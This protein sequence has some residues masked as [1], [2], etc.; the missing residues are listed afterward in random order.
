MNIRKANRPGCRC[1]VPCG[2]AAPLAQD[3]HPRWRH[4]RV[5]LGAVAAQHR[6]RHQQIGLSSNLTVA[7]NI[8]LGPSALGWD[9]NKMHERAL[10]AEH[11]GHRPRRLPEPTTGARPWPR[12]S[13][14]T[15]PRAPCSGPCAARRRPDG[16]GR[17][18]RRGSDRSGLSATAVSP[19]GPVPGRYRSWLSLPPR[20][21]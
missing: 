2:A 5:R 1:N 16:Q 13:P 18:G 3:R 7:A 15:W 19:S 8:S 6:L 9:K 14:A 12:C 11:G 20:R 4:R 10:T 21:L 17:S